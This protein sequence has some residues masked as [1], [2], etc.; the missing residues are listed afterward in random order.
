MLLYLWEWNSI[1]P[2]LFAILQALILQQKENLME[3]VDPK[4]GFKF[5]KEQAMRMIKVALL[6]T[7]PSPALRPTM[8]AALSML[9]GRAVI[10][11]SSRNLSMYGDELG[12]MASRD[13]SNDLNIQQSPSDTRSLIYLSDAKGPEASSSRTIH[14][15]YTFN[16]ESP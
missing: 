1:D 16:L 11:E 9:E 5:N 7:N 2:S 14:D 6:C 4:L 10:H 15:N 3:L 13:Y 12:S 8:S